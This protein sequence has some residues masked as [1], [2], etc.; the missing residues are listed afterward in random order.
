MPFS[1]YK[2][3]ADYVEHHPTVIGPGYSC[4][5]PADAMAIVLRW[6]KDPKLTNVQCKRIRYGY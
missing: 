6:E 1:I 4:Q 5:N 2:V 3:S